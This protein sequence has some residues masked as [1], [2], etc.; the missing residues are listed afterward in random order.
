MSHSKAAVSPGTGVTPPELAQTAHRILHFSAAGVLILFCLA[1]SFL[2]TS[3]TMLRLFR[4]SEAGNGDSYILYDVLQFQKTGVIYR[5]LS[6]PPYLPAQYSPLVYMLYSLRGRFVSSD[7][8][9]LGPR[10]VALTA[11]LGCIAI[12]I[13]IVRTLIPAR[14]AWLWGILL[15]TSMGVMRTWVLQI[16]GDFPAMFFSLLSIRLLM[17]R[18]RR[19]VILAGICAGL[20]TQFKLTFIAAL[21]AGALWLIFRKQWK[22]LGIFTASGALSSAGLYLLFWAREPRMLS[23]ILALS[24]GIPDVS[25]AVRLLYHAVREPAVLLALLAIPLVVSRARSRWALLL[26]FGVTSLVVSGLTSIQAGANDNYYFEA[27]FVLTPIAAMGALRAMAWTRRSAAAA[28]FLTALIIFNF[29]PDRA[30]AA[31]SNVRLL[32]TPGA[33]ETGNK[34][35]LDVERALRGQHMFSTVPRFSLTDPHPVLMEPYLMSY[36]QRL[37]KFNPHDIIERVHSAEFDVVVTGLYP[38]GWRG[39]P[40]ISSDLRKAITSS[41]RP[42][43]S[44]YGALLHLP[45]NHPPNDVFVQE[46][47]RIGCA[48]VD[49]AHPTW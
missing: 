36:E 2:L 43:C 9:F 23:Q 8:P 1:G 11:F 13:S 48:Q 45:R 22:E 31:I 24:P 7:N 12:V 10:L 34:M 29:L 28:L 14:S 32:S 16:R 47:S 39:V 30:E 4:L 40:F 46:L 20:A 21:A 27:L 3:E 26:V 19:A 35:F 49:E 25:G 37:G 6:Q 15:A 42:H 18:S 17:A 38:H 5:D 44:I 41:Y 33:L